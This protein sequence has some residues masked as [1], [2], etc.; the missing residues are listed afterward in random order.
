MSN[1]KYS[2]RAECPQCACGSTSH[3]TPEVLRSKFIGNEKE[4]DVLCP[5]CG[6]KHKGELVEGEETEQGGK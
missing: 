1:K 2:V 3:L 5:M 4:V 6:A